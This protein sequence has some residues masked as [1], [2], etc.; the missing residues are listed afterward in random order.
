MRAP[1][2]GWKMR[3]RPSQERVRRDLVVGVIHAAA[4]DRARG[5]RRR[6]VEAVHDQAGRQLGLEVGRLLRQHEARLAGRQ[7]LLD[8][9]GV[10]EERRLRLA[11]GD[12]RHRLGGVVRVAEVRL[13]L[14]RRGVDPQERP[15]DHAV[16]DRHVQLAQRRRPQ[17]RQIDDR[18]EREPGRSRPAPATRTA[19]T[20]PAVPSR[21]E[22][23][24][25]RRRRRLVALDDVER[26]AAP[27][28]AA[29]RS[30][31]RAD[32]GP[33]DASAAPAA[34]DPRRAPG[35]SSRSRPPRRP[36]RSRARAARGR[37]P[38]ASRSGG[39]RRRSGSACRRSS[40]HQA[41][42]RR[43]LAEP[44]ESMPHA[45]GGRRVERRASP[46]SRPSMISRAPP[47]ASR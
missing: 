21:P 29:P 10:H 8:L 16:Q 19:N 47:S 38:A 2:A 13:A 30:R 3:T 37:A 1:R 17:R 35:T 25:D 32:R 34:P 5:S 12:A 33:A 28:R 24:L 7:H 36:P 26:R 40:A 45:V 27:P 22:P 6:P 18:L 9:G 39:G 41:G 46:P 14:H 31:S 42:D 44:P 20:T 43:R 11:G 4:L 23:L 15:Q